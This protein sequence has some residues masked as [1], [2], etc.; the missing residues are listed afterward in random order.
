MRK[1]RRGAASARRG[2]TVRRRRRAVTVVRRRRRGGRRG[3]AINMRN[4]VPM[5]TTGVKDA[6]VG[7]GAK[8]AVRIIRSKS[9]FDAAGALGAGVE[10]AAAAAVG[11]L[12]GKFLGRDAARA[13]VQGA[14]SAP[15]ETFL[16]G[17]NIPVVSTAL[18]DVGD[19]ADS[20][21]GVGGYP[22]VPGMAGYPG[23]AVGGYDTETAA[24]Y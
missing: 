13:A 16:K 6:V 2:G 15:I 18:G 19:Y 5:L 11:L 7:V 22:Q 23:D 21:P 12:A 4:I 1:R 20:L 24:T 3:G 9:G 8:A 10:L 14:L 17:A